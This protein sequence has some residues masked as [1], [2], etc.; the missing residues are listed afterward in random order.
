MTTI[1]GAQGTTTYMRL[2]ESTIQYSTDSTFG[3][4]VNNVSSWPITLTNSTGS[5]S[6]AFTLKLVSNLTISSSITGTPSAS[7]GSFIMGTNWITIDGDFYGITINGL[8]SYL[9]LISNGIK[10][11]SSVINARSNINITKLGVLSISST[12]NSGGGLGSGWLGRL[13]FGNNGGTT[14]NSCNINLCWTNG[15]IPN[16]GG[17]LLGST[18]GNTTII[19]CYS[20]F[21]GELGT[22]A[23][24]ICG[25]TCTYMDISQC[26]SWAY[27]PAGGNPGGTMGGDGMSNSIITNTYG[28]SNSVI[29]NAGSSNTV[30]YSY[31]T[32]GIFASG[33]P[34]WSDETAATGSS[35]LQ[36]TTAG[37]N[38]CPT[39]SGSGTSLILVKQIGSVWTDISY[40]DEVPVSA[41]IPYRLT[42]FDRSPYSTDGSNP[43][44]ITHYTDLSGNPPY[45]IPNIND[46]LLQGTGY[47]Y[48][49]IGTDVS[50]GE[51]FS[52]PTI[53][54]GD[55]INTDGINPTD[56]SGNLTIG[57]GTVNGAY[58]IDVLYED[59]ALSSYTISYLTLTQAISC[60]HSDT[61]ILCVFNG[62]EKYVP[63][64]DIKLG[65]EVKTYLHGNKK[66]IIKGMCKLR[67]NP[68]EEVHT[69]YKLSKEKV[70]E[71]VEDLYVAGLH[72]NLVDEL[73]DKQREK[74]SK[75]WKT[76]LKIDD[77]YLLM[78]LANE[79]FE[80][81]DNS[82][83]NEIY[84]IVLEHERENGR[85]GVWANGILSETMSLHTFRR[86]NRF[87][88]VDKIDGI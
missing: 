11:G 29:S 4:G 14:R 73:T 39:Y 17:G 88:R 8:S 47:S 41:N 65:T 42:A 27:K 20:S 53:T 12:L 71:L 22:K 60:F 26:Y 55:V 6:S 1:S 13:Y 52:V 81:C 48:S 50:G 5:P 16:D 76:F 19:N 25:S 31:A 75:Y 79:K 36:N 64:K 32:N 44:S 3:S 9:G 46:R 45:T 54:M 33:T 80:R 37:T 63:I 23:G 56:T 70:H 74:I 72:S 43:V 68:K 49:F 10:S 51:P 66:V 87:E 57:T 69:L 62:I 18:S 40:Y 59:T 24:G 78:A 82:D 58:Q 7:T 2:N 38:T 83:I 34:N 67:N 35:G 86:K 85:Y 21:I 30:T 15:A 61:K 28:F 84:Q 77:K